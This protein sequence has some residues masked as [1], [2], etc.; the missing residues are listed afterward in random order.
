LTGEQAQY[1]SSSLGSVLRALGRYPEAEAAY[2]V[3]LG[4]EPDPQAQVYAIVSK[5]RVAVLEGQLQR[6]QQLLDQAALTMRER[7]VDEGTSGAMVHRLVQ[8]QIWAGQGRPADAITAFTGV[9]DTYT[10]L[11]CCSGPRSQALVARAGVRLTEH[12]LAA[13]AHD[14]QDAVKFAEQGQGESPSSSTTG[15]AWLMLA[16][17]EQAQGRGGEARHAYDLAVRNLSETLGEQH[18]DTVRARKGMS[19]T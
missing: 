13:A 12:Q 10:K 15:Q 9:L 18:P 11:D 2:D 7:H 19:D 1:T 5:A 6:A 17:V 4:A 3:A 14:A 8:G 16:E